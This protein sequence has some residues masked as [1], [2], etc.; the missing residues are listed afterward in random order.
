[1]N[2]VK[3]WAHVAGQSGEWRSRTAAT[4][5]GTPG[6]QRVDGVL[7]MVARMLAPGGARPSAVSSPGCGAASGWRR[8]AMGETSPGGGPPAGAAG[9]GGWVRAGR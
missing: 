8:S 3:V 4:V 5:A 2:Y 9:V 7:E 1:M 6:L